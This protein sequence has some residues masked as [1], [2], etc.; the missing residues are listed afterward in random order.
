MLCV[1]GPPLQVALAVVEALQRLKD[2]TWDEL[3]ATHKVMRQT[4]LEGGDDV[5]VTGMLLKAYD[6][7]GLSARECVSLTLFA[8]ALHA[9]ELAP[10][11]RLTIRDA[12]ARR[13]LAADEAQLRGLGWVPDDLVRALVA[14]ASGDSAAQRAALEMELQDLVDEVVLLPAEDLA[15]ARRC[16]PGVVVGAGLEV[17]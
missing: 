17:G 12:L 11:L 15:L 5:A 6:S 3:A 16:V 14:L 7:R 13:V 10:T 2:S 8:L 1:M 9:R 4:L